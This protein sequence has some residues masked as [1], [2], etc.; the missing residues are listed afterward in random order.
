M[1]TV[2]IAVKASTAWCRTSC[3]R[4]SGSGSCSPAMSRSSHRYLRDSYLSCSRLRTWWALVP[5][6]VL[7]EWLGPS[8]CSNRAGCSNAPVDLTKLARRQTRFYL[9]VY[10]EKRANSYKK[11]ALLIFCL[12]GCP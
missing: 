4:R 8:R 12:F 5:S 1:G 7:R 2:L 3:A 11:G 6:L 9:A 10:T